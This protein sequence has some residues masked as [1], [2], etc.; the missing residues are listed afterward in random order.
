M[1][2]LLVRHGE[3]EYNRQGLAL[4]RADVPLNETGLAQAEALGRGLATERFDAIYASPLQRAFRTAEA[5]AAHHEAH[6]ATHDGLIEM[7]VG[8]IEGLTFA[9]IRERIPDLGQNWGGPDGPTYRMPGSEERL[10]DVQERAIRTAEALR[11]KHADDV[12]CAVSHNFVILSL[13]AWALGIELANFRRLRHG[14]AA[15]TTL[16]VR[17]DRARVLS[18]NDTCHLSISG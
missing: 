14:V 17:P 6:V 16:D 5:I 4:G 11:E 10:V 2:L 12:V 9:V 13:I 7:D 3:T 15:V 8:E 1:R 18:L